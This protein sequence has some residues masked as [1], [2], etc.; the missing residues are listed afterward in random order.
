[1]PP[2]VQT[3]PTMT[4][5]GPTQ[6]HEFIAAVAAMLARPDYLIPLAAAERQFR[7]HYYGLNSAALLEDLFFDALG[8]FIRQ[9]SPRTQLVRPPTGQKGWDYDYDGLRISHKV[10]QGL[11]DIAALWDAT[12]T[13]VTHWSFDEPITYLLGKNTPSTSV[14]VEFHDLPPLKCRAVADLRAPYLLD[15]RALLIVKWPGDG[16]QAVLLELIPSASEQTLA[17][18]LSFGAIWDHV[19][20]H[21]AAGGAANEIDVLVSSTRLPSTIARRALDR[22][23]PVPADIGVGR[24]GGVYLLSRD[25][26]QNLSVKTNNRAILIPRD[27]VSTLLTEAYVRSLF[28]PL[29]LWYWPFAQE[30]PPDMYSSQRSEYEARFSARGTLDP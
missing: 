6:E 15:G 19:A 18:V 8:N 27:V 12:K 24:R 25:L 23:V 13:G 17:D 20:A 11:G 2:T 5:T 30:R 3:E 7:D 29:P 26:L 14:S 22:G 28:A 16:R 4:R 21:V 9:T 10:S 1:M